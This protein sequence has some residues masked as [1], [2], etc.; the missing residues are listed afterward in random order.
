MPQGEFPYK[1]F[2][3]T[4]KISDFENCAAAWENT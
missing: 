4:I 2:Y 3:T 1:V